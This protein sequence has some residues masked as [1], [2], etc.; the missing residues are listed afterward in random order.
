MCLCVCVC[1]I[2]EVGGEMT[3][4]SNINSVAEEMELQQYHSI[5]INTPPH[6]PHPVSPPVASHHHRPSPSLPSAEYL[7]GNPFFNVIVICVCID[8]YRFFI[9]CN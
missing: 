1:Y 8:A 6:P 5:N 9:A 4:T 3:G 7:S 2:D